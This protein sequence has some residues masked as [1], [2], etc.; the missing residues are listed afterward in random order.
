MTKHLDSEFTLSVSWSS[1]DVIFETSTHLAP[2]EAGNGSPQIFATILG[3]SIFGRSK[4]TLESVS[5]FSEQLHVCTLMTKKT[6]TENISSSWRT[7][8]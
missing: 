8:E 5:D 1:A 6:R 2:Q 7:I 3:R 4:L